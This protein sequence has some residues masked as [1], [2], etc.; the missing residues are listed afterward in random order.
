MK[1]IYLPK[2]GSG[3]PGFKIT[4]R[5]EGYTAENIEDALTQTSDL[6]LSK[7]SFSTFSIKIKT[8]QD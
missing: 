7:N 8:T 6:T 2:K 5:R 4:I 3:L 1:G